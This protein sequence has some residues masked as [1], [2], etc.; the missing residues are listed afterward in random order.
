MKET[1]DFN[2]FWNILISILSTQTII[3]NWTQDKGFY[4]EDFEARY[5]SEPGGREGGH[6]KIILPS[7]EEQKVRKHSF[8]KVYPYWQGYTEGPIERSFLSHKEKNPNYTRHS[9]YVISILHQF[10]DLMYD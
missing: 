6:V 7:G 9:K 3:K 2:E 4:G 10:E 8:N 1:L 5:I